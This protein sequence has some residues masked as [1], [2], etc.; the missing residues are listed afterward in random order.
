MLTGKLCYNVKQ[1]MVCINK[2]EL[3]DCV[4]LFE[5]FLAKGQIF[6]EEFVFN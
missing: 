1:C 6:K 5:T 4:L 3:F 2:W